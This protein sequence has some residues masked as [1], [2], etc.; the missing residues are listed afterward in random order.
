[1]YFENLLNGEMDDFNLMNF[2]YANLPLMREI[3]K[4]LGVRLNEVGDFY[5]LCFLALKDSLNC[6]NSSSN[7]PFISF[8][9]RCI[10]NRFFIF[11]LKMRYPFSLSYSAYTKNEIECIDY[12]LVESVADFKEFELI[13]LQIVSQDLW[14][15]VE[16]VLSKK[17]ANIIIERYKNGRTLRDIAKDSNCSYSY[18]WKIEQRGLKKL[19]K[20][21]ILK[22]IAFVCYGIEAKKNN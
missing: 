2:Y 10:K 8:F 19:R 4:D 12:S 20:N 16:S 15:I 14:K 17:E 18:I 11:K 21:E 22:E 5:Q 3:G 9:R 13:E 6:Y 1:M 7:Y